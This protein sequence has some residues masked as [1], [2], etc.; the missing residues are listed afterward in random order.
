MNQYEIILLYVCTYVRMYCMYVCMYVCMYICWYVCSYV[1]SHVHVR[2]L[3]LALAGRVDAI[4]VV[5]NQHLVSGQ[6]EQSI[7]TAVQ[8]LILLSNT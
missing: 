8:N 5:V 2:H 3:P 1:S 6:N 4:H 7:A